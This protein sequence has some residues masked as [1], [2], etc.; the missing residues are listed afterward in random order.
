MEGDV[1]GPYVY[2]VEGSTTRF[3]TPVAL[4][5]LPKPFLLRWS[6]HLKGTK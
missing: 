4:P 2:N 3:Q 5:E 1:T 6:E